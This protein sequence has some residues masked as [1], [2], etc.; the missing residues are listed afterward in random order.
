MSHARGRVADE[1]GT[2]GMII[3]LA[4]NATFFVPNAASVTDEPAWAA[5][6]ATQ[7]L[8]AAAQTAQPG[9]PEKRSGTLPPHFAEFP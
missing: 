7:Q 9:C 6:Q 5:D 4:R 1:A 3:V 8:L 2:T